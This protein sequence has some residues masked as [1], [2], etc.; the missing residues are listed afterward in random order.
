MP[1]VDKILARVKE[2]TSEGTTTE[3][4]NFR[5]EIMTAGRSVMVSHVLNQKKARRLKLVMTKR[6]KP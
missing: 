5:W 4:G 1:Y 2:L 3:G 6:K